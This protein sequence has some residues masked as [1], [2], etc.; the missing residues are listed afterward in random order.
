MQDRKYLSTAETWRE[1][2]QLNLDKNR[3]S[4]GNVSLFIP[5]SEE[6]PN[7]MLINPVILVSNMKVADLEISVQPE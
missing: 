1:N 2:F 6:N 7:S 4:T 3:H 5:H